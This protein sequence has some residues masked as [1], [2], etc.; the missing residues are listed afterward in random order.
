M[1]GGGGALKPVHRL[2]SISPGFIQLKIDQI[3]KD[4]GRIANTGWQK[5]KETIHCLHKNHV[6][7]PSPTSC[8]CATNRTCLPLMWGVF[9]TETEISMD[10]YDHHIYTTT[11]IAS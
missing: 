4:W 5:K 2:L 11:K 9:S 1:G 8:L 6:K 7:R 10:K 3:L